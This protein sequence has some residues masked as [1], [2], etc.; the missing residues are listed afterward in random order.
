MDEILPDDI[1]RDLAKAC[2][3]HQR[4]VSDYASCNEF[5]KL[6]SDLLHRLEDAGCYKTADRVMGVLLDCNPK[7]GAHCEKASLV[8]QVMKKLE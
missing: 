7:I 3:L 6:L 8:G 2:S 1:K 5:S 4:A